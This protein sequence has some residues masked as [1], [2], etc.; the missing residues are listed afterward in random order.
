VYAFPGP[1]W[2]R[3]IGFEG[4]GRFSRVGTTDRM[5]NPHN[6]Q[7]TNNGLNDPCAAGSLL[8]PLCR[9]AGR[10]LFFSLAPSTHLHS[11]C[12]YPPTVVD[13]D[14]V[15]TRIHYTHPPAVAQEEQTVSG[16][17][18]LLPHWV[19]GIHEM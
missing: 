1:C 5:A 3:P 19:G 13:M 11:V 8:S 18:L 16:L 12:K 6:M 14:R 7:F 17:N 4:K 15:T 10:L 2:G 9:Q